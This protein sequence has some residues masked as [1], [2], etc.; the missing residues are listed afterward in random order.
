MDKIEFLAKATIPEER[1]IIPD[2]RIFGHNIHKIWH[3]RHISHS[4]A[5]RYLPW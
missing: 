2:E 3:Q 1:K 4:A 5:M